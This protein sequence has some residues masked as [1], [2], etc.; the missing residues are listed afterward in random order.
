MKYSQT[1]GIFCCLALIGIC[2]MPWIEV[3]SLNKT[4]SGVDGYVNKDVSFGKQILSQGFFCSLMIL[5]FLIPKVLA[6]R[7]NI[8]I[9]LINLGWSFKNYVLFTM[10]RQGECPIV[11]PG[12]YLLIILSVVVQL[13]TFLPKIDISKED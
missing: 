12:L 1:L 5:L 10:C 4:F 11:K 2:F 8:F 6:K 7:I 3:T 13:M 9:G